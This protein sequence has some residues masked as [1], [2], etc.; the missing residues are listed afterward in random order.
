ML[1]LRFSGCSLDTSRILSR[2]FFEA[3]GCG[4]KPGVNGLPASLPEGSAPVRVPNA[5][6]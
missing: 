4:V 6:G 3:N 1:L 2:R 5:T